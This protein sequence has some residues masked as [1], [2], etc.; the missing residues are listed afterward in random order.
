MNQSN[1]F[2][3]LKKIFYQHKV[4]TSHLPTNSAQLLKP[5]QSSLELNIYRGQNRIGTES[6]DLSPVSKGICYPRM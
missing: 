4:E 6:F 2:D 5:N 3:K 1:N